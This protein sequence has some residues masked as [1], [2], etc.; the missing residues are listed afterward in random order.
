M[1][2]ERAENEMDIIKADIYAKVINVNNAMDT[3]QQETRQQMDTL[4][5]AFDE[6]THGASGKRRGIKT[7][8]HRLR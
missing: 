6:E 7:S 4:K 2:K 5:L 1:D 3:A 8:N